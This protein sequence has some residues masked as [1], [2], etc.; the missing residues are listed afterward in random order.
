MGR[1]FN[2]K[3]GSK[4]D[5]GT[6]RFPWKEGGSEGWDDH[7][8]LEELLTIQLDATSPLSPPNVM[9]LEYPAQTVLDGKSFG[10]GQAQSQL[11]QRSGSGLNAPLALHEIYSRW[12]FKVDHNFQVNDN[13]GFTKIVF[14]RGFYDDPD[15]GSTVVNGPYIK[16]GRG[17]GG[18]FTLNW[19]LQGTEDN[20]R[21]LSPTGDNEFSTDTWYELEVKLILNTSPGVADGELHTWIKEHTDGKRIK[22]FDDADVH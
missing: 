13:S 4:K 5:R 2:S 14:Y 21:I 15:T 9:R 22:I 8:H 18:K 19:D 12:T 16:F 10:P 6:G 1:E 7:E 20:A 3:A 17:K 11:F